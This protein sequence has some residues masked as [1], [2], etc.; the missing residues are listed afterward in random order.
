ST[1]ITVPGDFCLLPFM[2]RLPPPP[3]LPLPVLP[4]PVWE[5]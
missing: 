1:R 4:S 5:L 2:L 3:L